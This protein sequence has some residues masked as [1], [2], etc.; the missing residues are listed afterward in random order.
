M[1]FTHTYVR[2][3]HKQQ[4]IIVWEHICSIVNT[5][6]PVAIYT[7]ELQPMLY[8]IEIKHVKHCIRIA[9]IR[10][11][12]NCISYLT[13][14]NIPAYHVSLFSL[15]KLYAYLYVISTFY[16][17]VL[18]LK[19]TKWNHTTMQSIRSFQQLLCIDAD[20]LLS[21]QTWTLLQQ[22]YKELQT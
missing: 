9:N 6:Q 14:S 18:A 11:Q 17:S 22:L 7:D 19:Q 3:L 20:G 15:D 16:P 1:D 21:I 5:L 10:I 2:I 4:D 13:L 12:A 8:Q